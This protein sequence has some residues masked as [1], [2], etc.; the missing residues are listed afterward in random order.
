MRNKKVVLRLDAFSTNLETPFLKILIS[1]NSTYVSCIKWRFWSPSTFGDVQYALDCSLLSCENGVSFGL[2]WRLKTKRCCV[3]YCRILEMFLMPFSPT[4]QLWS[5]N[6]T[7]LMLTATWHTAYRWAKAELRASHLTFEAR[8]W[9]IQY[10]IKTFCLS[11]L[12]Y[13]VL[14]I[15]INTSP[16]VYK[17][18]MVAP[19]PPIRSFKQFTLSGLY[20]M[21]KEACLLTW[22]FSSSTDHLWLDR[23]WQPY[24]EACVNCGRSVGEKQITICPSSPQHAVPPDTQTSQSH[25]QQAWELV[26]RKGKRWFYW[27]FLLNVDTG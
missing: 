7:S 15:K 17:G 21:Y 26:C 18:K 20:T 9:L 8:E 12:A 4:E 13:T 27:K 14:F 16:I 6:L 11:V 25:C 24:E 23:L 1:L 3:F 5:L 22:M 19:P 2:N 10:Y